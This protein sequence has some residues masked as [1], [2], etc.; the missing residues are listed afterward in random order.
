MVNNVPVAITKDGLLNKSRVYVSRALRA[1][2]ASDLDEYQLWLSLALEVLGKSVLAEIHPSL[3]V[4]PQH[5]ESL[6]AA[7]G[8]PVTTD[9]RTITAKT[10]YSRLSALI[11]NFDR[12][13]EKF[14]EQL[15]LRRNAEL[16]SGEAPFQGMELE[17][18]EGQLWR[19]AQVMLEGIGLELDDWLGATGAKA[20][21]R[22][23][24]QAMIARRGAAEQRVEEARLR[25]S[26]MPAAQRKSLINDAASKRPYHYRCYLGE[27]EWNVTCPACGGNALM[28]G[29][30]INEEVTG[31]VNQEYPWEET[32]EKFY[33]AENFFCPTC[34]LSLEGIDE[35]DAAE[36]PLNFMETDTRERTYEPEY[37]ND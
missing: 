4:D 35:I 17:S 37:G 31:D 32:V 18:W 24:D 28:G 16:H 25:F 27:H 13:L 33:S 2:E 1:K 10:L 30:L 21:T 36:L 14:C 23:V 19:A 9:I 34:D 6:F 29:D 11:V 5:A 12:R 26:A 8:R 20:P 15:S 3:V 7:A 22:L